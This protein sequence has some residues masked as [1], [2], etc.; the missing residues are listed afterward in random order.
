MEYN[1]IIIPY[2]DREEHLNYFLNYAYPILNK[3][4]KNLKIIIAEQTNS[5]PFNR[6]K[7]INA[8]FCEYQNEIQCLYCHDIDTIPTENTIKELYNINSHDII[9][10][11]VAHDYSLGGIVKMKKHI[12]KII[13]G[14][15]N[16]IWGWGIEDRA[17]FYRSII[18]NIKISSVFT[19]PNS[20][21]FIYL[22]HKS[23]CENYVNEKKIIS[24][25]WTEA[26]IN[27]LDHTQKNLLVEEDGLNNID[28]VVI[29]K[30]FLHE[31][32]EKIIIDI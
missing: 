10:I 18:K 26:Y 13:N 28:Y 20:D 9:R 12:F 32:I 22:S 2:R 21:R 8:A 4:I 29:K 23:N 15:P 6:G 11:L 30:E 3:Y 7:I 14:F 1:I 24:D 25:I 31:N 17:L 19:K 16:N 27:S 5:K